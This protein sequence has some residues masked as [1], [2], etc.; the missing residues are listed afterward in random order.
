LVSIQPGSH[1][2]VHD[3]RDL[4][5]RVRVRGARLVG[6]L[7]INRAAPLQAGAHVDDAPAGAVREHVAEQV[8]QQEGSEEVDLP[9]DLVAVL[10]TG[11]AARRRQVPD[12]GDV[13][14]R[15]QLRMP[16][17]DVGGERPH[18]R[19]RGEVG[20]DRLPPAA[21]PAAGRLDPLRTAPVDEHGRALLR[22][23]PSHL[24]ADA[25]GRPGHQHR[26]FADPAHQTIITA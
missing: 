5:L 9:Y 1:A 26:L 17:R 15:V 18:A 11:A 7:E 10:G 3:H 24:L 22:E 8:R 13:G 4:R 21:D 16:A 25:V 23:A 14:E 20:H 19:E 6:P 12:S 2:G